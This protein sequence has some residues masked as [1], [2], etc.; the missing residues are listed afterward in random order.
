MASVTAAFNPNP[1]HGE[2][3]G[4]KWKPMVRPRNAFYGEKGASAPSG[5]V[6]NWNPVPR[7]LKLKRMPQA[8]R[9][10]LFPWNWML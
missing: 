8:V 4:D 2:P 1:K 10:R 6:E 7:E 5:N 9:F 3:G